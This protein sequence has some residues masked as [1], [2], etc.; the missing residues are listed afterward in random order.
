M[1]REQTKAKQKPPKKES[2]TRL[3]A[4]PPC[5]LAALPLCRFAG[6]VTVDF[7]TR[8]NKSDNSASH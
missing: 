2:T 4:L 8:K 7:P 6:R 1:F 5:R 3:A